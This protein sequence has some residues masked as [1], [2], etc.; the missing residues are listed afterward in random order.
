MTLAGFYYSYLWRGQNWRPLFSF[1]GQ[2][3]G[4][5]EYGAYLGI[6][7]LAMILYATWKFFSKDYPLILT[8]WLCFLLALGNFHLLSPWN[9][10]HSLP[11]FRSTRV[12]YR[13]SIL[14]IFMAAIICGR[15]IH[16]LSRQK[17]Y[18]RYVWILTFLLA[19]D[20]LTVSV[21]IL[22]KAFPRP[23]QAKE[24]SSPFCQIWDKNPNRSGC[25]SSMYLNSLKNQGT[26]NDYDPLPNTCHAIPKGRWDY[27]GEVFSLPTPSQG[28]VKYL[29]WSPNRLLVQVP[30]G[31]QGLVIVNQ[32]TRKG[33]QVI[34]GKK[35]SWKGLLAARIQKE[36][37][38]QIEFI[39]SPL[40]FWWGL[41]ISL[42]S[43]LGTGILLWQQKKKSPSL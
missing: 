34:G 21:P 11:V 6:L 29:Y 3:Y 23:L 15:A 4:F 27:Q 12:P 14:F 32:N 26:L 22:W 33:W 36:T 17:R 37:S 31:F 19:L 7:A 42:I 41:W 20:I 35:T 8:G 2:V 40:A 10:L 28:K 25:Y 24:V 1:S 30:K 9:L 43:I 38:G 18:A 16:L 39:Y 5:H 13:Y